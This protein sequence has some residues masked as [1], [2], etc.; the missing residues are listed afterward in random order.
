MSRLLHALIRLIVKQKM[1]QLFCLLVYIPFMVK[2]ASQLTNIE[3]LVCNSQGAGTG[4]H[5]SVGVKT[6]ID[7]C[8]TKNLMEGEMLS[9]HDSIAT[10]ST[11]SFCY[12]KKVS[13]GKGIGII[14]TPLGLAQD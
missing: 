12:I 7:E 5:T 10:H 13:C 3:I 9:M 6:S 1:Q 11:N 8:R 14:F 2:A 4:E